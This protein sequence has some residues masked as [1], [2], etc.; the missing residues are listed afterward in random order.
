MEQ[1]SYSLK[2]LCQLAGVSERTVRFYI[3]QRLLDP[4]IGPKSQSRYTQEHLLRLQINR[5]LKDMYWPLREIKKVLIGKSQAELQALAQTIGLPPTQ[6]DR[7]EQNIMPTMETVLL[8]AIL[9]GQSEE[10]SLSFSPA[11][12]IEMRGPGFFPNRTTL[13]QIGLN[14][15]PIFN[16]NQ[17]P[18]SNVWERISIA[19]GIELHLESSIASQHREILEALAKEIRRKLT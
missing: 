14:P 8:P 4:P 6:P 15:P 19:P 7:K 12:R 2:E 10:M 18:L 9:L 3:V 17:E 16:E 11:A 1:A 5:R 13:P